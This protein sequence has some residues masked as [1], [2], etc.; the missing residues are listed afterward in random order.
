MARLNAIFM[1][2]YGL[3]ED[4]ASYVLSTFPIVKKQDEAAYGRNHSRDF[5]LR[6]LDGVDRREAQAREFTGA[7][8][9]SGDDGARRFAA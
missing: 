6:L 8:A 5:I 9:R 2:L 7:R 4:D 1:R 3:S